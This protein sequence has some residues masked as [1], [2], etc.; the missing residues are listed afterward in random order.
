M[1]PRRTYTIVRLDGV[2]FHSWTKDLDRPY[3][4]QFADVLDLSAGW[5]I[6]NIQG[7][8][9]GYTQFDEV[10]ILLTDFAKPNTDAWHDGNL[11]K[12]SSI[13]ASMLTMAFNRLASAITHAHPSGA[14]FDARAFTIA[15]YV[16]VENYFI[17]RQKDAIKNS[18]QSTARVHYSSKQLLKKSIDAQLK[19][20]KDAGDNWDAYP[21][22]FKRGGMILKENVYAAPLLTSD[23]GR[24]ITRLLIPQIW[25]EDKEEHG[26]TTEASTPSNS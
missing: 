23:D 26:Q 6:R 21:E 20:I 17:W 25:P 8:I 7:A 24:D 9:F 1:L 5:L 11:Q 10:S 22:R 19:M 14:L 3:D 4:A 2:G 15:D 16:E 12:I 18:I 13:T